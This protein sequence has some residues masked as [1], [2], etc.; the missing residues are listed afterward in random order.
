MIPLIAEKFNIP[1]PAYLRFKDGSGNEFQVTVQLHKGILYLHQGWKNLGMCYNLCEGGW[2]QVTFVNS[3]E[4][5]IRVFDRK[6]NQV[7]CSSVGKKFVLGSL[8][9]PITFSSEEVSA[10]SM[11]CH[12]RDCFEHAF[13][14]R[15]DST[16]FISLVILSSLFSFIESICLS[17]L[18]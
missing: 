8:D 18:I 7:S 16:D 15:L 5:F 2:L 11:I 9:V 6:F 17:C 3:A 13:L 1:I 12:S 14:K 10:D 4:V